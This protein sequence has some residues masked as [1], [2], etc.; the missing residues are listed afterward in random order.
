[1]Q[2]IA[3][4]ASGMR[5]EK[6]QQSTWTPYVQMSITFCALCVAAAAISWAVFTWRQERNAQLVAIGVGVLRA[7]PKKEPSA[8]S[9]REWALDLIDANSG[10][11][12]FSQQARTDLLNEALS[13]KLPD[14][15]YIGGG[16]VDFG[17]YEVSPPSKNTPA[18][19]TN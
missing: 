17:G 8:A 15:G 18:P 12:K 11:V 10:G 2:Y 1:M 16:Y 14:G 4:R 13:A 7:D 6:M 3:G 19:K 5:E 9:A